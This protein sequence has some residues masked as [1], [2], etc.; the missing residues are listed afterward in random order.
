MIHLVS[1][2]GTIE[3]NDKYE[4]LTMDVVKALHSSICC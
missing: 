3:F 2:D 1:S 4:K